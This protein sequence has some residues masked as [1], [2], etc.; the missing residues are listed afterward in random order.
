[1]L[2]IA[3]NL[4]ILIVFYGSDL[5]KVINNFGT[6][7][8]TLRKWKSGKSELSTNRVAFARIL[9]LMNFHADAKDVLIFINTV[10]ISTKL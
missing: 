9:S 2:T 8:E 5:E 6:V 10:L 3:W 1:M 7:T 4:I